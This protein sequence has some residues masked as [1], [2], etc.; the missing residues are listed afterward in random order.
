[1]N[2]LF[3]KNNFVN[4][5]IGEKIKFFRKQ[6]NMTQKDLGDIIGI[7]FQ[8]IQKYEQGVNSISFNKLLDIANAL[9]VDVNLFIDGLL[10][11][12]SANFSICKFND[13]SYEFLFKYNKLSDELKSSIKYIVNA[14]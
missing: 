1:M 8:Q 10:K 12:K 9:N 11:V 7:S 3:S 2:N 5:Y 13:D 4:K 6:L 14:L